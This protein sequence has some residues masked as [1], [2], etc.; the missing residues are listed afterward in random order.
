MRL[1]RENPDLEIV[2]IVKTECVP[3]DN[4]G[5]WAAKWGNVSVEQVYVDNENVYIYGLDEDELFDLW[6]QH[7]CDDYYELSAADV[8]R[9]DKMAEEYVNNLSWKKVILVYITEL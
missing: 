2:P 8:Q 9:I 7:N 1:I 6:I 5:Y 3:N 4:W